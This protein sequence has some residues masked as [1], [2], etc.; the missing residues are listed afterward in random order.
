MRIMIYGD[1]YHTRPQFV[2]LNSVAG[3]I[4]AIRTLFT[5]ER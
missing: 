3:R 1:T 2:L 4:G 5:F